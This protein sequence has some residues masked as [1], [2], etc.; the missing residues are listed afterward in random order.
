MDE[1][2]FYRNNRMSITLENCIDRFDTFEEFEKR[3]SEEL[4]NADN[5]VGNYLDDLLYKYD[6][7]ASVVSVEA[8]QAPAYVGNNKIVRLEYKDLFE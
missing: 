4:L 6:K 3:F 2:V 5:R 1:N 8:M 7:K